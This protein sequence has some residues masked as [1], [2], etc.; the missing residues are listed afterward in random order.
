LSVTTPPPLYLGETKLVFSISPCF[1]G[2]ILPS[3]PPIWNLS[4]PV[5]VSDDNNSFFQRPPPP[6]PSFP[7]SRFSDLG[8]KRVV[9][10]WRFPVLN[11]A[12]P[13]LTVSVFPSYEPCSFS[14]TS[15]LFPLLWEPKVV[16]HYPLGMICPL[17][18]TKES[19]PS[20]TAL[21]RSGPCLVV[22]FSFVVLPLLP[23]GLKDPSV[24]ARSPWFF[25]LTIFHLSLFSFGKKSPSPLRDPLQVRSPTHSL[26]YQALLVD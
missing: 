18:A 20:P 23:Q 8:P 24:W 13:P 19:F 9:T 15:I 1:Q 7:I 4:C 14:S 11:S 5:C 26:K 17:L 16:D 12:F 22:L 2:K 3:F 21:Y 25:D 6:P 10:L